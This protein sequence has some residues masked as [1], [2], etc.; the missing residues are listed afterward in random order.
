MPRLGGPN[1]I[2]LSPKV[3]AAGIVLQAGD[4]AVLFKLGCSH[5][6]DLLECALPDRSSLLIFA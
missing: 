1:A 5:F 3:R 4:W 2:D 6:L